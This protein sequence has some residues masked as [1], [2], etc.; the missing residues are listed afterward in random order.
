LKTTIITATGYYSESNMPAIFD[1]MPPPQRN[2]SNTS[3]SSLSSTSPPSWIGFVVFGLFIVFTALFFYAL[4]VYVLICFP[5]AVCGML[6]HT[7]KSRQVR[8]QRRMDRTGMAHRDLGWPARYFESS[9]RAYHPPPPR[10]SF[11]FVELGQP[12][13]QVR[14]DGVVK[15]LPDQSGQSVE[16][17]DPLFFSLFDS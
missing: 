4:L 16:W 6:I 5:K 11:D 15:I 8:G 2:S 7:F 12:Y 10:Q 3:D 13:K 1:T 14:G 17:Q 9:I